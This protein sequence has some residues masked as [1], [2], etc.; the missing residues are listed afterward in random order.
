MLTDR[1]HPG[2]QASVPGVS[3]VSCNARLRVERSLQAVMVEI[4]QV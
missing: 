4:S 2:L 3:S 1:L